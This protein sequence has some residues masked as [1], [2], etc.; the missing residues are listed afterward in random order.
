MPPKGIRS[1]DGGGHGGK[2]DTGD[3]IT[4][5]QTLEHSQTTRKSAK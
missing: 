5:D 3:H 4:T 1:R 2:G